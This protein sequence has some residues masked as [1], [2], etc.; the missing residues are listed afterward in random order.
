MYKKEIDL[1][2]KNKKPNEEQNKRLDFFM[3]SPLRSADRL[4]E[5][6]YSDDH[7]YETNS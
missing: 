4:M 7:F 2:P 6:L 5:Q 1:K 3:S